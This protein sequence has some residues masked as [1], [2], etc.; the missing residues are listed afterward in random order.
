MHENGTNANRKP[1][2]FEHFRPKMPILDSGQSVTL[3]KRAWNI[4]SAILSPNCKV[5]EKVMD[6]FQEF[7]ERM[8]AKFKVLTN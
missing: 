6:G 3:K 5:S 4:F 1:S 7:L 2:I 8:R